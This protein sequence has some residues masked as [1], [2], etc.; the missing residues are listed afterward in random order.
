MKESIW[1]EIYIY[2]YIHSTS[3]SLCCIIYIYIY[4]QQNTRW[5]LK[6]SY[7]SYHSLQSLL[8]PQGL[9]RQFS[10]LNVF[11]YI[12]QSSSSSL[13]WLIICNCIHFNG[14]GGGKLVCRWWCLVKKTHVG[15]PTIWPNIF[16][17]SCANA[18]PT[19]PIFQVTHT[20]VTHAHTTIDSP[21]LLCRNPLAQCHDSIRRRL[22]LLRRRRRRRL[23]ATS[24]G[25]AGWLVGRRLLSTE[26]TH[27]FFLWCCAVVV[28][29]S[30]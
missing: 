17:S 20:Q 11:L 30:V 13:L 23:L 25:T 12:F 26:P 10:F 16:T 6:K 15:R 8:S 21:F 1:E 2:S 7:L 27:A 3:H 24:T 14:R 4:K 22:S 18:S 19:H 5:I 29:V 9:N 28:V